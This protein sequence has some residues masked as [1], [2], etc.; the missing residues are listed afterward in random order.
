[1]E[2]AQGGFG[3]AEAVEFVF[4]GEFE[5]GDVAGGEVFAADAFAEIVG[6]YVV[7]TRAARFAWGE[8]ARYVGIVAF[9]DDAVE[10]FDEFADADFEAGFFE[11][12]AGDSFLQRLTQFQHA[13]GDRPLAAQRFAGAFDQ[14]R[15][16]LIDDYAADADERAVGIFAGRAHEGFSVA[17]WDVASQTERRGGCTGKP[18]FLGEKVFS[19]YKGVTGLIQLADFSHMGRTCA[20]D[21]V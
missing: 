7:K 18:A 16:A 17:D 20:V 6:D 3:E 4:A 8:V 15:A 10:N 2:D 1:V 11:D 12:F 9:V 21:F 19:G 14:Y 5:G 13:A